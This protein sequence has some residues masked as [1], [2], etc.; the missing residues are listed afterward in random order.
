LKSRNNIIGIEQ[1]G[2]NI[3][4]NDFYIKGP[5]STPPIAK[6]ERLKPNPILW[7]QLGGG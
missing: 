6:Q 5:L 4:G 2:L 3:E 7:E 1:K